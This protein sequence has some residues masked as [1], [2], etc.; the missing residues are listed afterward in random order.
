MADETGGTFTWD[1]V[2]EAISKAVQDTTE[3]LT[4]QHSAAIDAVRAEVAHVL[5][6]V[7]IPDHSAGPNR[8]IRETW[9]FAE[10]TAA[11]LGLAGLEQLAAAVL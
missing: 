4:A 5:P 8:E 6:A 2:Q 1:D 3:K 7:G 10:Q 9:S 11:R